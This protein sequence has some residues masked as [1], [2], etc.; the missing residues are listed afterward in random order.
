MKLHELYPYPSEARSRKR[1]GRGPGSGLG[2]TSGKGNKGQKARA[3][4][5]PA[6]G[7]EGGQMPLVRRLPKRGF[8]NRFQVRYAV[9]NLEQIE[10]HFSH[11]D[12][13]TLEDLYTQCPRDLPIKILGRGSIDRNVTVE[14]HR[15]SKSAAEKIEKAGGQAKA[16][17]A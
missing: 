4:S 5:G 3:G 17:E 6:I 13:I 7:F 9:I 12:H 15:F 11:R 10:R 1:R 8:K 16:L 14:A 2:C